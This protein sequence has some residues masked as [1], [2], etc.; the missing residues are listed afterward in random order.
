MVRQ[1]LSDNESSV[2]SKWPWSLYYKSKYGC[3]ADH[4]Y[5]WLSGFSI[6]FKINFWLLKDAS[7]QNN[8]FLRKNS[9]KQ[10]HET[11]TENKKYLHGPAAAG[12][13]NTCHETHSSKNDYSLIYKG[14]ELCFNC[15]NSKDIYLT[16]YHLKKNKQ[17]CTVCHDPHGS[18]QS[19]LLIK[20]T[21]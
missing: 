15:H 3:V 21:P 18:D 14:K 4:Y 20:S 5:F 12:E 11:V 16:A 8:N 9:C 17:N 2:K 6:K 1:T 13:C 19:F 7:R 10:C